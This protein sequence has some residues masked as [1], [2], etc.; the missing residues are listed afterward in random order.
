MYIRIITISRF[1]DVHNNRRKSKSESSPFVQWYAISIKFITVSSDV[2]HRW[3]ALLAIASLNFVCTLSW[4]SLGGAAD[5]VDLYYEKRSASSWLSMFYPMLLLPASLLTVLVERFV[6]AKAAV[7]VASSCI[8]VSAV[9]R[10]A[11]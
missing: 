10:T 5:L 4:M 8:M 9:F 6:G 1:Q 3:G 7:L 11:L 2:A